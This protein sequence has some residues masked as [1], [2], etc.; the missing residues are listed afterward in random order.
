MLTNKTLLKC[1]YNRN[2][3]DIPG[4]VDKQ[5]VIDFCDIEELGNCALAER[6][7]DKLGIDVL[8]ENDM[9]TIAYGVYQADE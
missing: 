5:N 9:N 8:I 7:S 6:L 1:L 4:V 2:T 3:V